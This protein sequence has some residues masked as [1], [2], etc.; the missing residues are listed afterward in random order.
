[1]ESQ[2]AAEATATEMPF[3]LY[4]TSRASEVLTPDRKLTA[5]KERERVFLRARG[6]DLD[7]VRA[8]GGTTQSTISTPRNTSHETSVQTPKEVATGIGGWDK[9]MEVETDSKTD[10]EMDQSDDPG[11]ADD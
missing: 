8:D 2:R 1:M 10:I 7:E 6:I 9:S 5:S 3:A 4:F 11:A